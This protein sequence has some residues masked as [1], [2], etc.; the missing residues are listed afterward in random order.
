MVLAFVLGIVASRIKSDLKFPESL[1]QTLTIYLLIA[2][3][4][5]GG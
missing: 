3:G 5:K 2:I 1:Y 4:I